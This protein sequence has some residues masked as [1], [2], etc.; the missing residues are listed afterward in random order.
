MCQTAAPRARTSISISVHSAWLRK[1]EQTC[2]ILRFLRTG[3]P[4]R[5]SFAL[6]RT[7]LGSTS[8]VMKDTGE[9]HTHQ[10]YFPFGETRI[11]KGSPLPTDYTF[12]MPRHHPSHDTISILCDAV[13]G[14]KNDPSTGSGQDAGLMFYD[15]IVSLGETTSRLL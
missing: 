6:L 11:T 14:Q 7:S 12:T 13:S 2:S 9:L 4:K 3:F 15:R 10:T 5:P 1:S 8:V